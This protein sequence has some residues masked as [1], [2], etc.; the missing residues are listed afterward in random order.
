MVKDRL[1]F[2]RS[3]GMGMPMPFVHARRRPDLG[4]P[5]SGAEDGPPRLYEARIRAVSCCMKVNRMRFLLVKQPG[6]C[7]DKAV[8]TGEEDYP[9]VA[10]LFLFPVLVNGGG[11]WSVQ[12]L[13]ARHPMAV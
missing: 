4:G 13:A 2:L 8:K 1:L 10:E 6:L 12:R 3:I 7:F 11:L 9:S 5:L